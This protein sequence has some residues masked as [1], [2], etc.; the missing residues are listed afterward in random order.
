[1]SK[2]FLEMDI[3]E[4]RADSLSLEMSLARLLTACDRAE[5]YF[6][7]LCNCNNCQCE[8]CAFK[9]AINRAKGTDE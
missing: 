9:A 5:A 4:L 2:N 8:H 3:D 7:K 6:G 1:M